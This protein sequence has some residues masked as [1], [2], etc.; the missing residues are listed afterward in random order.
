MNTVGIVRTGC[1]FMVAMAVAALCVCDASAVAMTGINVINEGYTNNLSI[2]AAA[3]GQRGSVVQTA[4][5]V[6]LIGDNLIGR[7]TYT[8]T[9]GAYLLN[10]GTFTLASLYAWGSYFQFRA[11]GGAMTTGMFRRSDA[12][13]ASDLI[14]S[15]VVFGGSG[16]Y[17]NNMSDLKGS[18]CFAV[19]DEAYVNCE[20]SAGNGCDGVW[21]VGSPPPAANRVIALN[22]GRLL[23]NTTAGTINFYA[24]NGGTLETSYGGSSAF[25]YSGDYTTTTNETTA[26]IL[27]SLIRVYEKG[28]CLINGSH[29]IVN[30][31]PIR[32]TEGNVVQSIP[33]PAEHD[34]NDMTFVLPP[35]VVITDSTGAGSNATAVADWDHSSGKVTNITVLCRGDKYSATEGNVTANLRFNSNEV[36]LTEPL[37]CTVGSCTSGDF[38]FGGREEGSKTLYLNGYVTNT[39]QGATIVDTDPC[40]IY[41]TTNSSGQKTVAPYGGGDISILSRVRFYNTSRL[42]LKSGLLYSGDSGSANVLFPDVKHLE[43]YGGYMGSFYDSSFET[44]TVGGQAELSARG[45]A[46]PTYLT[47]TDTLYVDPACIK[48]KGVTPA[49]LKGISSYPNLT[50]ASGAKVELTDW[51][52]LT[53][54]KE[55]VVLDLSDLA[56]VNGTP[57]LV[58]SKY[59][60]LTWNATEKKLY[61]FR[62]VSMI[63]MFV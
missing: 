4:G 23:A 59:G 58:E 8:N 54:G 53:P 50:F 32:A 38:T 11:T 19:K 60:R 49:L 9:A 13:M 48:E 43:L 7:D 46:A 2:A 20:Y 16:A 18:Y 14:P 5:D 39:Y 12:H 57:T 40:G 28:G 36:L 55:V 41:D 1:R 22:G 47:V 17:T 34:L 6:N 27:N 35:S 31:P 44:V 26:A 37:V 51:N 56:S 15:D 62:Y 29:R 10:G 45:A 25:G 52:S 61:A 33:I 42:I 3:S 63:I 24:F 30:P 21:F